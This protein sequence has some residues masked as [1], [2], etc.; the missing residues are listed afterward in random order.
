[1]SLY[2]FTHFLKL[3]SVLN[4]NLSAASLNRYNVMMYIIGGKR[5]DPDA[6]ADR[7]SKGMLMEAIGYLFRAYSQKRRRLGPLAVLHPLRATALLARS[8]DEINLVSLLSTLFHDI[9][10][11]IKARD[12]D[13]HTWK[14][15]EGQLYD[16]MDRMPAAAEERLTAN[17]ISLT[18]VDTESYYHYIGRLLDNAGDEPELV[19]VKLADRL[20]NTLDM[21]I[22][23]EDPLLGIDFFQNIFQI[24]FVNNY[25]GFRPEDEQGPSPALNG[26]RRLHQL[27]KTAVLLSLIRQRTR[28]PEDRGLQ[29]LF[30]AVCDASL[31]EAQRTLRHLMGFHLTDLAVQRDL[32]LQAMDYCFSG[33]SDL[34]TKPDGD[35]LLDGLFSTYFAHTSKKKLQQKLDTL[36]QNK[37]LMVQASIAFIVIFLSFL[38]DSSFY[39]KGVSPE[40]IISSN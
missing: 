23:L 11:D 13:I 2:D 39:I 5:L 6:S 28:I 15:M 33:R 17:L 8:A 21:R 38:N 32:L 19:R 40:G 3:S 12:F 9:L 24:M 14:D 10:E 31:K 27:F 4:Y 20:D 22:E 25:Q 7:E 37:P 1:M 26:A 35:Q 34:V 36:Y 29:I 18:R 30:N 16:L